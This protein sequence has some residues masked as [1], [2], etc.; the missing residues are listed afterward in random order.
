[1]R[2][3]RVCARDISRTEHEGNMSDAKA[4]C[5]HCDDEPADG[6][7]LC[8]RCAGTDVGQQITHLE[9]RLHTAKNTIL[10]QR[11]RYE[12]LSELCEKIRLALMLYIQEP[13]VEGIKAITAAITDVEAL[14]RP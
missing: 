8:G 4:P 2:A 11:E 6:Y 5:A 7:S 10:S 3:G 1:M 14:G 9:N 12:P 13:D